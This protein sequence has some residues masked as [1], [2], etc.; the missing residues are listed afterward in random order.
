[1]EYVPL[2]SACF[3]DAPSRMPAHLTPSALLS[4]GMCVRVLCVGAGSDEMALVLA[5]L[6]YVSHLSA[7]RPESMLATVQHRQPV[8]IGSVWNWRVY[9]C[10]LALDAGGTH[11]SDPETWL[12]L[13]RGVEQSFGTLLRSTVVCAKY[14][15]VF[16]VETWLL[17]SECVQCACGAGA[18]VM[19]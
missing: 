16:A 18:G 7:S 15:W 13:A 1:M 4:P 19:Y 11:R 5:M 17:G 8:V 3:V 9:R 6:W 12:H 2:W 10:G 14:V